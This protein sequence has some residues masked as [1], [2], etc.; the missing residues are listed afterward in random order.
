MT[1]QKIYS[2]GKQILSKYLNYDSS[3]ETMSIL[4]FCFKIDRLGFIEHRFEEIS[5]EKAKH[6]L[7][8]VLNRAKGKPL[9]YILG[10][11]EFMNKNFFINEG[12][13]I[14]REETEILVNY[15]FEKIKNLKSPCILEL[16]AGSG[17]VSIILKLQIK[18]AEITAIEIS[19][20]A[21]CCMKKNLDFYK[22][23][24]VKILKLDVLRENINK[25][26]HFDLLVCNPPYIPTSDIKHLSKEVKNEPIIALDGGKDG[27]KF[28]R[29][30]AEN[31]SKTLK[32]SGSLTVEIG[33]N[34]SE[35]VCEIF[36]SH[37][38]K[39]CVVKDFNDV[40]RIVCA[41]KL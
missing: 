28:Y 11:W 18:T 15:S 8:L 35:E 33:I 37:G 17:I 19:E 9:Q 13:L 21:I 6:F 5:Q 26:D 1:L 10:E 14:P 23:K 3:F 41:E 4:N 40:K 12:V 27:L 30:I 31:W 16:C 20:K 32:K 24:D 7:K 36:H 2:I 25:L 29:A 22:I 38:F 34:Q 39:T